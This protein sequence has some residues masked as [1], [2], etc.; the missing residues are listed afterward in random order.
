LNVS[1]PSEERFLSIFC[2]GFVDLSPQP[3]VWRMEASRFDLTLPRTLFTIDFN[4]P[5][6]SSSSSQFSQPSS[7]LTKNHKHPATNTKD[8]T[9]SFH[10]RD[11]EI[12]EHEY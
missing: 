10:N 8:S 5:L 4:S 9:I 3:T 2:L 1:K 6:S 11:Q 12:G 7:Q